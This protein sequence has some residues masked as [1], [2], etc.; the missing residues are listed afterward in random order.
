MVVRYNTIKEIKQSVPLIQSPVVK[1]L[2]PANIQFLLSIGLK[3]KKNVST[4]YNK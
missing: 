2:T 1:Q 3:P 4:K